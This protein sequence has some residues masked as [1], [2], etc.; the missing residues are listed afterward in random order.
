MNKPIIDKKYIAARDA[1]IPAAEDFANQQFGK[2]SL[3]MDNK[4]KVE[5]ARQWSRC[6]I[7]KMDRLFSGLTPR[8]PTCGVKL[9]IPVREEEVE[10]ADE[11]K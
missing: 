4:G 1:L 6:F 8:C 9:E 7:R 2:S 11:K 3:G 10:V 5:Y